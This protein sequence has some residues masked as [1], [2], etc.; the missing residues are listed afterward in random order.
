MVI[1]FLHALKQDSFTFGCRYVKLVITACWFLCPP[2]IHI[3]NWPLDFQFIDSSLC[4]RI[5]RNYCGMWKTIHKQACL[6][7]H[8]IWRA[9]K[10]KKTTFKIE[11]VKLQRQRPLSLFLSLSMAYSTIHQPSDTY[12]YMHFLE[13]EEKCSC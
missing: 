11:N 10:G 12:A 3:C 1:F 7:K 4:Y 13:K 2:H 8:S 9:K 5:V 6:Y